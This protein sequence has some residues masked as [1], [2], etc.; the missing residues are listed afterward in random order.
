MAAYQTKQL[1]TPK[2]IVDGV[3]HDWPLRNAVDTITLP[4]AQS[5]RVSL[6]AAHRLDLR[7]PG[8][9]QATVVTEL[10]WQRTGPR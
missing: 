4:L 1:S 9:A 10:G 5:W 8:D 2:V 6:R 7:L 3:A